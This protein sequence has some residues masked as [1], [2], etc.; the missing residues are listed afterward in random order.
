MTRRQILDYNSLGLRPKI[1]P[2]SNDA[3]DYFNP[4]LKLVN[5]FGNLNSINLHDTWHVTLRDS[6]W[7][8]NTDL[9][10]VEE[11][12]SEYVRVAHQALDSRGVHELGH[13]LRVLHKVLLSLLYHL[14][15][16]LG[17]CC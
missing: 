16:L 5:K 10:V 15:V 2:I 14:R 1:S 3:P 13:E 8:Q 7:S 4:Q 9:G 11:E 17:H 12:V 6:G